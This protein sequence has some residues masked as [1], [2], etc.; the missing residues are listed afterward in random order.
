VTER[1]L[2]HWSDEKL[3]VAYSQGDEAAFG[4]LYRRYSG[5]IYGYLMSRLRD[6]AFVDDVFQAVFMK[7]HHAR[8][9]YDPMHSFASWIFT[10]C[11][12]V[13]IDALRK[14]SRTREDF[15]DALEIAAV[16]P[17]AEA[18]LPS[19]NKLSQGQQE[20]VKL[21]Y[22]EN[23][24]FEEIARKLETSPA[25]VRQMVSRSIKR[26]KKLYGGGNEK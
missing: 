22:E 9:Q 4:V 5:K 16:E 14:K 10:I 1:S 18:S 2:E 12:S 7:L 19:L 3:M 11:R 20:V 21:R 8:S 15:S 25:N 24:S 6:A 13:M 17:E 23:L 26:L